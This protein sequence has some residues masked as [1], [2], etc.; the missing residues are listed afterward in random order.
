MPLVWI[1]E[2]SDKRARFHKTEVCRQLTKKPCRGV[3]GELREVDLRDL[4]RPIPCRTCY[5]DLPSLRMVKQYCF[6]C[7]TGSARACEHNGGV[8]VF[9][10][11]ATYYRSLL[12]E[13]GDQILKQIYVWPDR[14][15]RYIT[16]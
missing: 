9:I 7:N 5:D 4:E 15:H 11:Y 13:P 6:E 1:R 16:S 10:S 3:R 14:A 2:A 12:R 8:P